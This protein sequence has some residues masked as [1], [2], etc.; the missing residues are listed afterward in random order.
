[1]APVILQNV[2][3]KVLISIIGMPAGL[4]LQPPRSLPTLRGAI[5]LLAVACVLGLRP[6]PAAAE[7]VF[8]PLGFLPLSGTLGSIPTDVS[9]NG[10]VIVGK[11]YDEIFGDQPS[12]SSSFRWKASELEELTRCSGERLHV[13]DDGNTIAGFCT[14]P[15]IGDAAVWVNGAYQV[16][17]LGGDFAGGSIEGVSGNGQVFFG[18]MGIE[19]EEHLHNGEPI[20]STQVFRVASGVAQVVGRLPLDLESRFVASSFDGAAA[21]IESRLQSFGPDG[22]PA[23]DDHHGARFAAGTEG[24]SLQ[25][26]GAGQVL[27]YDISSD[28]NTIVGDSESMG[29]FRW[30]AE[31]GM[32]QLPR[33]LDALGV[34]PN[35]VSGD[36]KTIVGMYADED[37]K[38]HACIWTEEDGVR[39]LQDMMELELGV[40][41]QGWTLTAATAISRD[42]ETIVGYGMSPSWPYPT[43]WRIGPPPSLV[44][45][46]V[47][48]ARM[49]IPDYKFEEEH[50]FRREP[51]LVTMYGHTVVPIVVSVADEANE[52][53]PLPNATITVS[54]EGVGMAVAPS[55][56]G[57][58][59]DPDAKA[60]PEELVVQTGASGEA[61][62]YLH[63][64]ELYSNALEGEPNATAFEVSARWGIAVETETIPVE[65]NRE[66]ILSRYRAADDY[67]PDGARATWRDAF[68]PPLEPSDYLTT[69]PSWLFNFG[70]LNNVAGTTLCT[71]YQQY[72]LVFLNEIRH[73][74][75]GWLLN[76][77]D[78]SPLQ[79]LDGEH[80]FVGLYPHELSY[81]H[82]RSVILDPWLAQTRAFFTFD[83]FAAFMKGAANIAPD[84]SKNPDNPG[85]CVT[86]CGS[87]LVPF[88]YPAAGGRYPYFPE[89]AKINIAGRF[90]G[91]QRV[92][93]SGPE[94]GFSG[95]CQRH[96][97]AGDPRKLR[98]V[99]DGTDH[100]TV[101]IGSP[102][103]F[104]VTQPDGKRFGF[105]SAAADSYVNEVAEEHPIGFAS[106]PEPDGSR[107][108]HI[109]VPPGRTFRLDFPAIENGTM[110]VAVMAPLGGVWGG[111]FGVPITAGQTTSLEVDL[112]AA[113]P[114][115]TVPGRVAV[116]CD[117]P[118]TCTSNA[119][120]A[121]DDPCT[122]RSCVEGLCQNRPVEGPA[123]AT[124]ACDRPRPAACDAPKLPRPLLKTSG[125]ACRLLKGKGMTNEKKRAKLMAKAAKSWTSATTALGK[126][127]VTK[128][129][130]EACRAALAQSYAEAGLRL[131][132]VRTAAQ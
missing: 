78:Y 109:D 2:G 115:F 29:G 3:L 128:K 131:E 93:P 98:A 30:R 83:E 23:D 80:H 102:V 39:D 116:P 125:K 10:D 126:R 68:L 85:T 111:W 24:G 110:D 124:C 62:L 108:W 89:N 120:C 42:G 55:L 123:A 132:A 81:D 17:P 84:V 92:P 33:P 95:W 88:P 28:G 45:M 52:G 117:R 99:G 103:R 15:P 112:D 12:S 6:A 79:L 53:E 50:E 34:I 129:L 13:S 57:L 59:L 60:G 90:D 1:M 16:V 71:T 27:P 26:I 119:E 107:G 51:A 121:S 63:V 100:A 118:S 82:A 49:T 38:L 70:N 41:L 32:Q 5:A 20:E 18:D 35:A 31:T 54:V 19:L 58:S 44:Q 7:T 11:L 87:N 74:D 9:G 40:D 130:S 21:A 105:T 73:S 47:E 43:G 56:A 4:T 8:E 36:G 64:V 104:L 14:G 86:Y 67:I 25:S 96:G 61:T 75:D 22:V 65:D 48:A 94:L 46:R 101:L 106:L 72:T 114:A 127:A 66:R 37:E 97:L 77:L 69:G 122:P 113:C 91:C 76:G